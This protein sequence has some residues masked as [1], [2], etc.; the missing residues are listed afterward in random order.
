MPCSVAER[1]KRRPT[2]DIERANTLGRVDLV[3]GNGEQ[4]DA[5]AV[6]VSGNLSDRLCGVGMEQNSVLTCD[7][8]YLGDRLDRAYLVVGVH[9]ADQDGSG[10][11]RPSDIVCINPAKAV[12][13]HNADLEAE[14]RQEP[15]RFDNCRMLDGAG[16]D[17]ITL[18]LQRTGHALECEIVGLAATAGEDD[19]VVFGPEQ[20]GHLAARMFKGSLRVL[21]GPMAA[22]RIAEV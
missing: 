10:A 1:L 7:T 11:D 20:R 4:V 8:A 15:A 2:T 17:V 19:F 3:A 9:E 6:Q 22:R 16:D 5:K 14:L 12:D 21:G 18:R 13:G